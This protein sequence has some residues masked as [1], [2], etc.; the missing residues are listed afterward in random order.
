L[1]SFASALAIEPISIVM[2]IQALRGQNIKVFLPIS[3]AF[4]MG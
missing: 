1:P 3:R 4:S 2:D